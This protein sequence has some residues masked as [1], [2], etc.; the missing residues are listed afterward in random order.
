MIPVWALKRPI[1]VHREF[2]TIAGST[3]AAH[4]LSQ[5]WYWTNSETAASRD[6]WF[7][8][9]QAEW[10][11]ETGLTRREQ[12]TARKLLKE[13][14][15]LAEERRGINPT[16]WFRVDVRAVARAIRETCEPPT[17]GCRQ[18]E[19]GDGTSPDGGTIHQAM[20]HLA[21]SDGA[22]GHHLMAQT[23]SPGGGNAH[24]LKAERA[25]STKEAET[26]PENTTENTHPAPVGGREGAG[27]DDGSVPASASG[28]RRTTNR[29]QF[30]RFW[31]VYPKKVG[32][33]DA[34][35]AWEKIKPTPDDALTDR[36]IAAAEEQARS[37]QWRKDDGRF[38]PH[39]A[40]WLNRGSWED[41]AVVELPAAP[42]LPPYKR[43]KWGF[44]PVTYLA[45]IGQPCTAEQMAR[46]EA[47]AAIQEAL[48]PE[49]HTSCIAELRRLHNVNERGL[50]R[51]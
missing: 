35:R 29:D 15:L 8:K 28:T 25:S 24:H 10:E 20:A 5:A 33:Q 40:T 13:R 17:T 1:V 32:K 21:K 14:G 4:F 48:T 6:G 19:P 41:E 46:L 38:I 12:E 16:I 34:R 7:Y 43:F 39:P 45:R 23:A 27:E 30:E 3:V 49:Q 36:M 9:T 47:G 50:G 44:N 31:A 22:S 42:V 26:T 2:R 11:Q 37:P 51:Y 18:H